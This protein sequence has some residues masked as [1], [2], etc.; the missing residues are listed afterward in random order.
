MIKDSTYQEDMA[1]ISIYIPSN[2]TTKYMK[3]NLAELKVEKDNSTIIAAD[4][5]T[6]LSIMNRTIRQK[7]CKKIDDLKN[8]IS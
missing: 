3:K 5:N 1:I 2:I 6:P 4:F 8:S 7:I